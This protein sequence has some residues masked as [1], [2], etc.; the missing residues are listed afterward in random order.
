MDVEAAILMKNSRVKFFCV[1]GGYLTRWDLSMWGFG[2]YKTSPKDI[3]S[4]KIQIE[5]P[6]KLGIRNFRV[7][8][9]LYFSLEKFYYRTIKSNC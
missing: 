9:D 8:N 3:K 4:S 2:K 5:S 6:E 7:N 1:L